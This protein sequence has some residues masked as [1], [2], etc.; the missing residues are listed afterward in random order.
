MKEILKPIFELITGEFV[1]FGNVIYNYIAMGVV[2]V[3]AFMI[4]FTIVGKLYDEDMIPGSCIGSLIHWIVRL[5]VFLV[6][7]YIFSVII[8]LIKFIMTIPWWGW[9]IVACII[10]FIGIT[11]VIIKR[12][13]GG[14]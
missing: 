8:W 7:F 13:N 5:L 4:A 12:R 2:G 1:L 9:V 10:V 3:I 6:V 14:V 11:S